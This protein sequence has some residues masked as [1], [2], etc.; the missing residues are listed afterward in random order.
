MANYIVPQVKIFQRPSAQLSVPVADLSPVIVGPNAYLLRYSVTDEKEKGRLGFYDPVNDTT[1]NIPDKPVGSVL[2]RDYVKLYIEKPLLRYFADDSAS[3][4][5]ILPSLPNRIVASATTFADSPYGSRSPMFGDRDVKPGDIAKVTVQTTSGPV[6]KWTKVRAVRGQYNA[7]VVLSETADTNNAGAQM[8][9]VNESQIAGASNCVSIQA[10]GTAYN[11]LPSGHINETYDVLVTQSSSGGNLTTARLRIISA[12]GTDN[13]ENVVPAA[14]G[15]YFNIGTRGLQIRFNVVINPACVAS[16][17]AAG[18][19][20]NDLVVGQ[21]WRVIVNQAFTPPTF[22]FT[23]E[24][25]YVGPNDTTYIVTVYRGGLFSA[26]VKPQIVVTTVDGSDIS[27]PTTVPAAATDVPVGTYGLTIQ[28]GGTALRAGDRYYCQ[29]QAPFEGVRRILE[30]ADDFP[31]NTDVTQQVSV[32]LFLTEP[33]MRVPREK[34][35]DPPNVNWEVDDQELEVKSDLQLTTSLFTIGGVPQRLP[36]FSQQSLGYGMLYLEYRAWLS[37]L[38]S[39][40][41]F[42]RNLSELEEIPGPVDPDNPL[43]WALVKALQN[44]TVAIAY[45]A[46]ADP[47]SLDSWATALELLIGR[48]DLWAVVPLSDNPYVWDLVVAH[49]NSQSSPEANAW[50]TAWIGLPDIPEIPIVA[51]GSDVPGHREPKTSN[52]LAALGTF[53]DDPDVSGTQYTILDCTSGNAN[54]MELGVR[55]GDV[56]RSFFSN[57]GFGNITYQSFVVE[58]IL[59]G[60]RLRLRTGPSAPIGVPIKF[61]VWRSLTPVQ[62][63]TELARVAEQW[64]SRRIIAVWGTVTDDVNRGDRTRLASALAAMAGSAFFHVGLTRA[65]VNGFVA[66]PI[67]GNFSR[68][69][70]DIMADGGILLVVYDPVTLEV[71]VR[72][73]ITTG[74][75][76]DINQRE[77]VVTRMVDAISHRIR[78]VVDPFIGTHNVTEAA[79]FSIRQQV[80]AMFHALKGYGP[81]NNRLGSIVRELTVSRHEQFADHVVVRVKLELPYPINVIEVYIDF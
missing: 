48:Y 7:S 36:V 47:K 69:A 22:D 54:F 72:H 73:A 57:D 28:F 67:R 81:S 76:E 74:K 32:E 59:S 33:V 42:V 29:V 64:N 2:D 14:A 41:G 3:G 15:T 10:D 52:G 43:K 23:N 62:Q 17:T 40:I 56:V 20:P 39:S 66:D 19:T 71:F 38:T 50:R 12:S 51:A 70:L 80:D 31:S 79:L 60:Q 45:V 35:H 11:G 37:D 55:P 63:A 30:F 75:T 34:L 13:Q 77:E 61:E 44:S 8:Y 1:Y 68:S 49:V 25:S 5:S 53:S 27:G 24:S 65:Q 4:D 18:V 16:A 21:R 9:S 78:T 46:V 58:N 6:T 26:P